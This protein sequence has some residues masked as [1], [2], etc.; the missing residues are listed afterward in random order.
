LGP[1]HDII[2]GLVPLKSGLTPLLPGPFISSV[3]ND[4][5]N[6]MYRY[7]QRRFRGKK[8]EL[9]RLPVILK[10]KGWD[11]RELLIMK[12]FA[13]FLNDPV[14]TISDTYPIHPFYVKTRWAS[15]PGLLAHIARYPLA[16]GRPGYWEVSR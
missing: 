10:N 4:L 16:N 11:A 7:Q 3:E 12:A 8:R 13:A 6:L 1:E 5:K 9:T 14:P 2:H 15:G